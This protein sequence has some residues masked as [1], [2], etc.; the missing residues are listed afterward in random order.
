MAN[1][2][3]LPSSLQRMQEQFAG[4]TTR[5]RSGGHVPPGDIREWCQLGLE[6]RHEAAV[7]QVCE[8]LLAAPDVHS[9]LRPYWLFFL[10]TAML[11]ERRVE[12]GAQAEREALAALCE[13]PLVY[14]PQPAR[15]C[16]ADPQVEAALWQALARLAAAGVRAFAHAGTL[17]G[18]VREGRLLPGDKDLDLGLMVHDLPVAH[19]VLTGEGWQPVRQLF[20]IDNLASYRHPRLDVV[21]DLCGLVAEPGGASLLGG[22]W[23]GGMPAAHQ[24][25]TRFPG[26]LGLVPRASPAGAI[27]ALED[28]GRWLEAFYGKAWRTPDPLFD[29]IIGA[30]NLIGFSALTQWYAYS[31]I[32]NAWLNGY[33][34]KA[35]RLTQLVLD[36]HTPDDALLRRVA[37][38]LQ[39]AL[40]S[41][42]ASPTSVASAALAASAAGS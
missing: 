26:P 13:A 41:R 24:R 17:L 32:A 11:H 36:R 23:T 4:L 39:A 15:R 19:A 6:L 40:R 7:R 21:L 3:F 34:E 37:Q 28:P 30:H 18:L 9:A 2:A 27:W 42:A 8:A 31:R 29:T 20:A 25:L 16:L 38:T 1:E 12:A 33:W 35:W 10:G 14:N 22:F 5:L